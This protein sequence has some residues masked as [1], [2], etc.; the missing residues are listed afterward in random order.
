[1]NSKFSAAHYIF[2]CDLSGFTI[3]FQFVSKTSRFFNKV[4]EREICFDF[5][6]CCLKYWKDFSWI[7]SY[8]SISLHVKC[9]YS[10]QILTKLE[11]SLQILENPQ[12]SHFMKMRRIAELLR[13]G[14]RADGRTG[15]RADGRTDG[16][17]K[18]SILVLRN[19]SNAPKNS[20][21][22]LISFP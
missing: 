12:V 15:G 10:R 18:A 8:I 11:V 7:L 1:V 17:D 6:H 20:Q 2:I 5:F 19:F 16:H 22:E 4:F 21:A 9:R 3:F 13:A 14:G